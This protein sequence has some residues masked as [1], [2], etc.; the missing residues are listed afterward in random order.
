[1]EKVDFIYYR[2]P[3]LYQVYFVGHSAKFYSR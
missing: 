1:M 3:A 2:N